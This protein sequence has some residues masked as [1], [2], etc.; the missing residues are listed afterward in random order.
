M[1][2]FH[3]RKTVFII[4]TLCAETTHSFTILD[5]FQ[6]DA[7]MFFNILKFYYYFFVF[8]Q[9][10]HSPMDTIISFCRLS[11]VSDTSASTF[12]PPNPMWLLLLPAAA[13]VISPPTFVPCTCA[14]SAGRYVHSFGA[15]SLQKKYIDIFNFK[16]RPKSSKYPPKIGFFVF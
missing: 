9:E 2:L 6:L 7:L 16:I 5:L 13:A 14:A 4:L 3:D 1:L 12:P 11:L 10:Y 8:F 15:G